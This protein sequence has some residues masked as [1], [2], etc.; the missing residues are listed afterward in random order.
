M[1]SIQIRQYIRRQNSNS[2]SLDFSLSLNM[3]TIQISS[4]FL[5]QRRVFFFHTKQCKIK[6]SNLFKYLLPSSNISLTSLRATKLYFKNNGIRHKFVPI[7]KTGYC[8]IRTNCAH[9]VIQ[10]LYEGRTVPGLEMRLEFNLLFEI[11]AEFLKVLRFPLLAIFFFMNPSRFRAA[12]SASKFA[13]FE[14]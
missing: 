9:Y 11:Y 8:I 5:L 10:N 13:P 12:S 4:V 1:G 7:R 3:F 2:E 14:A 6:C